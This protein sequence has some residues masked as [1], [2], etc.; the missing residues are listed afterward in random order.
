LIFDAAAA[1]PRAT[2]TDDVSVISGGNFHGEPLALRLDYVV[3]ALTE[4][5]AMSERRVDRMV[6][7]NV[8]ERHLPPFLSP[9]SG[10]NSGLMIAQ[11]TAAS[12]LNEMRSMGRPSM[13]TTPVSG[14]QE[15]HVSMSATSAFVAQSAFE[16]AATVVAIELLVAAQAAE[17]VDDSLEHGRGTG[18]VYDLVRSVVP[19]LTT[20]R[21]LS[22]D[23]EAVKELVQEGIVTARITDVCS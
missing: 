4:L 12:L 23:I 3:S 16:N 10:L 21:Q 13:D 14:G 20:D 8:Q 19:P 7:P 17:F 9:K 5:A 15:D 1:D 22:G 11:Y 18:A 2:G 6:N